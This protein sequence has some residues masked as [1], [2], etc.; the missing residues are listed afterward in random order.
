MLVWI[1]NAFVFANGLRFL[2]GSHVL[3]MRPISTDFKK[4]FFKIG[5]HSIIH[6][7]KNYFATVF[8]VFNNKQYPNRLLVLELKGKE[9]LLRK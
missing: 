5:L 6:T 7:F 8:S 9:N 3:F 1:Q 4:K 2:C